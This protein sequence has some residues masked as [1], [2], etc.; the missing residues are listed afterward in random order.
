MQATLA[1]IPR[2]D[3]K[4]APTWRSSYTPRDTAYR[5][6]GSTSSRSTEPVSNQQLWSTSTPMSTMPAHTTTSSRSFA[7]TNSDV[8]LAFRRLNRVL[9]ENNI[10]KELRRQEYFES[11]SDKRVRLDSERHRKRFAVAVGRAVS[12]SR[13]IQGN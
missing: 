2:Q 11:P 6:A 4:P 9:Q 12:L 1:S 10:K 7:V 13:R 3:P 5:I 8:G